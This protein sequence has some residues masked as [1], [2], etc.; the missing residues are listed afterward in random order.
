MAWDEWEHL[1]AQAA[2]GQSAHMQLN[3]VDG[4]GGTY[5]PYVLPGKTGDLKVGHGDLVKIGSAAHHLYD[6]LWNKARVATPSSDSAAG[7]LSQQGFALGAG[8]QHVSNRWEEQLKSLMDA[9]AQISNHMQVT[10]SVHQNDENYIQRQMSSIDALDDG[11][12][13]RVGAPGK[14]NS[15][16]GE[17]SKGDKKD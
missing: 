17:K 14:K 16:Y 8:L 3:H 13:E 9:C 1:K 11:F 15:V 5:G 10:K 7:D 2:G 6:Q 4:G 12:D